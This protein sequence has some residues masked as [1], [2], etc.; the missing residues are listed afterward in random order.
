[1]IIDAKA[2]KID[3]LDSDATN[4][5]CTESEYMGYCCNSSEMQQSDE[6]NAEMMQCTRSSSSP[7]TT[8]RYYNCPRNEMVCGEQLIEVTYQPVTLEVTD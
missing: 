6:C 4:Y 3:C 8:A 2:C 5:Y 1:M 7:S